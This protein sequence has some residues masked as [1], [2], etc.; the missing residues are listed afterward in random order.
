MSSTIYT[1]VDDSRNVDT[2]ISDLLQEIVGLSNVLEAIGQSWSQNPTIISAQAQSDGNLWLCVQT[3]LD[4]C[5][6]TLEKLDKRL[7]D[8]QKNSRFGRG[9]LRRPTKAIK[10]NMHMKEIVAYK[11]RVHWH[12][13]AMQ[14]ALQ[15]IHV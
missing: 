3:S 4:D 10:M 5:K 1:F 2:N 8:I 13:S 9:F 12:N 7:D 6:G 15:M 11:Q 14:S